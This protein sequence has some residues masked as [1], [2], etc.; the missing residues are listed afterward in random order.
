MKQPIWWYVW[1]I[2]SNI[3]SCHAV[4]LS[5][6]MTEKLLIAVYYVKT[7]ANDLLELL[8]QMHKSSRRLLKFREYGV[9]VTGMIKHLRNINQFHNFLLCA[10]TGLFG[11]GCSN[12]KREDNDLKKITVPDTLPTT[13]LRKKS[14]LRI[15]MNLNFQLISSVHLIFDINILGSKNITK[16]GHP[17]P[18][19]HYNPNVQALE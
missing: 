1:Y 12:M 6:I 8:I 11:H 3:L 16:K 15:S 19:K 2:L 14:H 13:T 10:Y 4:S 17:P 7:P 18:K 9:C 5:T